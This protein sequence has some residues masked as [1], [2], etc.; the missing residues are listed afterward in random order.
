M[1]TGSRD[2]HAP[3]KTALDRAGFTVEGVKRQGNK[4]VITVSRRGRD[5]EKNGTGAGKTQPPLLHPQP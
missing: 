3:L 5:N 1:K 2:R 4:T